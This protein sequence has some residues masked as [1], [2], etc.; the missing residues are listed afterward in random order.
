MVT[1]NPFTSSNVLVRATALWVAG[2]ACMLVTWSLSYRSLPEGAL[3]GKLLVSHVRI[4]AM[5]FL[6]TFTR[7]FIY[8]LLFASL[9]LVLANLVKVKGIPLGYVLVPY[10]WSMYGT[11]LGTNSFALPS[12]VK[13]APSL[14]VLFQGTGVYEVTAYTLIASAT[15]NLSRRLEGFGRSAPSLSW[16]DK[17]ILASSIILL[18]LSN[19]AEA[20]QIHS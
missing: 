1:K 8:N 9:P 4:I 6:S 2:F 10:H 13:L 3:T 5:E 17:A 12:P 15:Y 14:Q 16:G 19:L 18:A 7:I 20:L 11:M